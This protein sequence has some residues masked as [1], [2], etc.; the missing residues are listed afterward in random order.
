MGA[1]PLKIV[2][3]VL[4]LA[5][6][7]VGRV[8]YEQVINPSTP[9]L[10]QEDQYDCASFGSQESAQSE[11]DRDPRD[12]NN[13]DPD[14]DGQACDDYDYGGTSTNSASPRGSASP[15]T[16]SSPESTTSSASPSSASPSSDASASPQ[17][18]EQD[19]Q[20]RGS[21]QDDDLMR[22]GGPHD[23]PVPLM[24]DGNCPAEFPTRQNGLC[25]P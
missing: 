19:G 8:T 14:G 16:T 25:H 1:R 18:D 23:G 15:T 22:S 7:F 9:A 24:P 11:L 17:A 4:V 12:P 10:A 21:R 3:V 13:L 5:A 2:V 6:G 20:T